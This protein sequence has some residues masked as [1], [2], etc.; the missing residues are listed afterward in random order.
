MK[1]RIIKLICVVLIKNIEQIFCLYP[2]QQNKKKNIYSILKLLKIK[3]VC[4][5]TPYT[6]IFAVSSLNFQK[7]F[8]S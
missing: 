4:W 8:I 7:K 2:K 1:V 3:L 5:R 6:R